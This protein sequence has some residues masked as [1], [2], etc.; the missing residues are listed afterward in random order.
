MRFREVGNKSKT[1]LN[2]N[3]MFSIFT[4]SNNTDTI[5]VK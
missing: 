4:K 3:I 2:S 5:E 1:R